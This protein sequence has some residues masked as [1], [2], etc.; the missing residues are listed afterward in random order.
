MIRWRDRK[1]IQQALIVPG[2]DEILLG[3]FPLEAMD[4]CVHPRTEQ[5]VGVHGDKAIFHLKRAGRVSVN[6]GS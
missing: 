2:A 1:T 4:L 5:L 3:A 6:S